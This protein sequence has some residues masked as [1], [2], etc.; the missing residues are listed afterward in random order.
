MKPLSTDISNSTPGRLAGSTPRAREI[1]VLS[2]ERTAGQTNCR[3]QKKN[4][5]LSQLRRRDRDG[6]VEASS[7][8]GGVISG[9]K[10]WRVMVMCGIKGL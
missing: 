8:I 7:S 5:Q 3:S 4:V 1:R 9:Y 10:T 6:T 2:D